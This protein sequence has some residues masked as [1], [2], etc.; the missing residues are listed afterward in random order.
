MLR[1]WLQWKTRSIRLEERWKI[2]KKLQMK[3]KKKLKCRK[4]VK[5]RRNWK[6]AVSLLFK[7]NI[8]GMKTKKVCFEEKWM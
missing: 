1:N 5:D 7:Y 4:E 8:E 3:K 2:T 6:Q